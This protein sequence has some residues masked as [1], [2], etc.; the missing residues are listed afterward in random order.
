MGRGLDSKTV[1][2]ARRV[3][4][5][6]EYVSDKRRTVT[7]MD[8]SREL[9][10]PQSSTS[11]LLSCLVQ[12][13]YLR[14]D[15]A[16]RTFHSTVRVATIGHQVAAD[17]QG[18]GELFDMVEALNVASGNCAMIAMIHRTSLQPVYLAGDERPL[19]RITVAGPLH[20]ALGKVLLADWGETA[21]RALIHRLNA[22]PESE[23]SIRPGDFLNEM[24]EVRRNG[25]AISTA[26]PA[27]RGRLIAIALPQHVCDTPLSLG[28]VIDEKLGDAAVGEC[29]AQMRG[30]VSRHLVS[31]LMSVTRPQ[32]IAAR[33]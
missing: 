17:Q 9:Q 16:Q 18:R 14:H 29:V 2:S 10:Y 26:Y 24:D 1:K 30:A 32:P 23:G 19:S 27:F 25:F 5:L 12:L 11:E 15:R 21:L 33:G 28:M 13:G 4:E 7:V 8:V 22:D 6:L 31:P 20:C 3:L